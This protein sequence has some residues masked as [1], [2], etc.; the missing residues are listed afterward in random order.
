MIKKLALLS[1][2]LFVFLFSIRPITDPDLWWHLASGRYIVEN[3]N[4]PTSDIFSYTN[5]GKEWIDH[6]WLSQ[7]IFFFAYNTF[8]ASGLVLMKTVLIVFAFYFLYLRSRL[9]MGATFSILTLY[10]VA[11]L[12]WNTWLNRP[13]IFTFFFVAILLFLLDLYDRDDSDYLFLFP[14]LIIVWAN[15]HAGFIVGILITLIY[16]LGYLF[17]K[18]NA[19]SKRLFFFTGV[20]IVTSLINP[21]TYR[22]L[23]YPLQYSYNSIHPLFIMEWQSPSFH[24]FSIYELMLLVL[25]FIFV[26]S[27]DVPFHHIFL[28]LTF[29]HL[30]LF[31]IRN[32][33]LFALVIAP[34]VMMYLE[35][36][37]VKLSSGSENERFGIGTVEKFI[38]RMTL[39]RKIKRGL[40]GRFIPG[41]T[42]T[43]VILALIIPVY[44]YFE[45]GPSLDVSP[46]GFPDRAV[47]YLL[48]ENPEGNLFNSYRWGGFII[49]NAYPDYKVF[50]DGRAD[51]YGD[52]IYEYL[53]VHR[54]DSTWRETLEKYD[55]KIV[56]IP[57]RTSLDIL[58]EETPGWQV[59]FRDEI[60]VIYVKE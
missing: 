29:V 23:L 45:Y 36:Y 56:I 28:T 41:F 32:I 1:F 8:G 59:K 26:K 12:S 3:Q 15:L 40:M 16:S 43:L 17:E 55:V 47:E 25:I 49:W 54:L 30:S 52:F 4:I 10:A 11:S 21:Y 34:I 6:E 35:K 7:I 31:A 51:M 24:V 57:S 13:M 18:K 38:N 39:P 58:L 2:F 42:Y 20:S 9:H 19:K 22:L 60:S 50:I 48:D 14:I 46:Y 44:N 33:S 27:Q 37:I 53:N 5:Y